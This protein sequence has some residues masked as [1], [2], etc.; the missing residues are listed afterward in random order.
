MFGICN[1]WPNVSHSIVI[2]DLGYSGSEGYFCFEL[3]PYF[4]RTVRLDGCLFIFLV[5][6][7]TDLIEHS[8]KKTFF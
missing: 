5:H 1:K 4:C 2:P 3:A 7:R 6:F 8:S